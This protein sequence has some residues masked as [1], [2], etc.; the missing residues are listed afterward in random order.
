[1]LTGVHSQFTKILTQLKKNPF[2]ESAKTGF[3]EAF[4]EVARGGVFS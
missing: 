2:V 3:N 1:M 4:G